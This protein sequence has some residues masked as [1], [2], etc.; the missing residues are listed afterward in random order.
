MKKIAVMV[1][2][3]GSLS[4]SVPLDLSFAGTQ[5]KKQVVQGKAKE[6]VKNKLS[7]GKKTKAAYK[8]PRYAKNINQP[9]EGE[10][11][12]LEGMVKD[13]NEQ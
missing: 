5:G 3:I 7:R 11:L 6:K 10:L 1:A 9:Q 8:R 13:L 2:M 12:K 4:L